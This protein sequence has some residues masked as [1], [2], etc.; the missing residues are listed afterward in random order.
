MK[1]IIIKNLQMFILYKAMD[2]MSARVTLCI[3]DVS[4]FHVTVLKSNQNNHK[5]HMKYYHKSCN[6]FR[7]L[8]TEQLYRQRFFPTADIIGKMR[9]HFDT[10]QLGL[11]SL[12]RKTPMAST[13]RCLSLNAC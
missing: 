11:F 4:I 12:D 10:Y 9:K 3:Q 6:F 2:N 1:I 13:S 5:Q 7:R 8:T